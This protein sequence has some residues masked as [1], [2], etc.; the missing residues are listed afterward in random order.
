MANFFHAAEHFGATT[1]T[2]PEGHV[3][4]DQAGA[5]L[6]HPQA[7][8]G[9]VGNVRRQPSAIVE[10]GEAE[11]ALRRAQAHGDALRVTVAEGV[12]HRLLR[13]PVKLVGHRR[14]LDQDGLRTLEDAVYLVDFGGRLREVPQ[15]E[16]QAVA[17]SHHGAQAA[18]H[19]PAVRDRL[20]DRLLEARGLRQQRMARL[21]QFP[22]QQ[23]RQILDAHQLLA[24][25]VVQV[26]RHALPFCLGDAQHLGLQP[27]ARADVADDPGEKMQVTDLADRQVDRENAPVLPPGRYFDA[28]GRG[29]DPTDHIARPLFFAPPS[30]IWRSPRSS[31][32]SRDCLKLASSFCGLSA[33]SFRLAPGF[34]VGFLGVVFMA[35][36]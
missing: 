24:D 3:P 31:R 29:R 17:V 25:A 1:A 8:A 11:A 32:T 5:V 19:L 16:H 36:T 15:R 27:L 26:C 9:R 28:Q 34:R 23:D 33:I 21:L 12:E 7:H 14:I 10:H 20:D 30:L 35:E 22:Q 4:A 6:H 18:G 13:D 2:V